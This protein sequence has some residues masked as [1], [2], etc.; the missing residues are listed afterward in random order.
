MEKIYSI[1]LGKRKGNRMNK[2]KTNI[3]EIKEEFGFSE[4]ERK[5]LH[6]SHRENEVLK[7]KSLKSH[8]KALIV[9][10]EMSIVTDFIA[11]NYTPKDQ[12]RAEC[13]K[14]VE[15]FVDEY[16]AYLYEKDEVQLSEDVY[17]CLETFKREQNELNNN[18]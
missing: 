1:L 4:I 6:F 11:K 2:D 5:I 9:M 17:R 16:S 12:V 18:N 15:K 14:Y 13:E 7:D 3:E 10:G 8:E